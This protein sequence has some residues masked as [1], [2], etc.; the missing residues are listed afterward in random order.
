MTGDRPY[1]VGL[2]PSAGAAEIPENTSGP[3]SLA[4]THGPSGSTASRGD[5]SSR[6]FD[7]K[8]LEDNTYRQARDHHGPT[9]SER[10]AGSSA[11]TNCGQVRMHS[12][13]RPLLLGNRK[14]AQNS[15]TAAQMSC[16]SMPPPCSR[17][18]RSTSIPVA[19]M[20]I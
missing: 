4:K 2:R 14:T 20:E 1:R 19:A 12:T 15:K 9:T 5:E 8:R 6:F 13:T 11:T 17:Y 7:R 18:R 16:L 10:W 3:W